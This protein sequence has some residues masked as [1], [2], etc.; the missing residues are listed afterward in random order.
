MKIGMM[1]AVL[2]LVGS[3][4]AR[5]AGVQCFSDDGTSVL[6][7]ASLTRAQEVSFKQD[8]Q[9][10]VTLTAVQVELEEGHLYRKVKYA[11]SSSE[12]PS[13]S[14]TLVSRI[15][16]G[17]GGCGRG[18]CDSPTSSRFLN[19]SLLVG[20]VETHYACDEILF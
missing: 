16:L 9:D 1:M 17:R 18:G 15:A 5:A 2:V 19:A 14:L 7:L 3:E 20:E 4:Q 11:L 13:A 8:G 10:E 6:N 12:V